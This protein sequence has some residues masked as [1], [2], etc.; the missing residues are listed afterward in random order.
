VKTFVAAAVVL[1]GAVSP[2]AVA[3]SAGTYSVTVDGK[4]LN[5]PNGSTASCNIWSSGGTFQRVT[6]QITTN[7]SGFN[8][9]YPISAEVRIVNGQ[10]EEMN[11]AVPWMGQPGAQGYYKSTLIRMMGAGDSQV[12]NSGNTYKVSGHAPERGSGT[13]HAYEIDVTCP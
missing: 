2:V 8:P 4:Q 5:N 7:S 6:L 13:M 9:D 1:L 3:N 10:M 11:L 12:A